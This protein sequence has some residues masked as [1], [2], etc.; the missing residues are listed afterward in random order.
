MTNA[1]IWSGNRDAVRTGLHFD[2]LGSPPA[3]VRRPPQQLLSQRHQLHDSHEG[4]GPFIS[5][6]HGR[7]AI[8]R[9]TVSAWAAT[10]ALNFPRSHT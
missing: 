3:S 10:H 5:L 6:F 4:D 7:D 8:S 9:A 1:R 2:H